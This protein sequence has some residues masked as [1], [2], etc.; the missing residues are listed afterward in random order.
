MEDIYVLKLLAGLLAFSGIDFTTSL[1][2]N[3]LE[4]FLLVYLQVMGCVAALRLNERLLNAY[5]ISLLVLLIGDILVGGMWMVKFDT[6][7]ENVT[8]DLHGQLR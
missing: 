6:L 5:W 1:S 4:L 2:E 7:T 3:Q 8:A